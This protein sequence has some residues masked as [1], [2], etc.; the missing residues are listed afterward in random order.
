MSIANKIRKDYVQK[1]LDFT[2]YTNLNE[3]MMKDLWNTYH[4][5]SSQNFKFLYY[6][7]K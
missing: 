3:K 7:E 6:D 4:Y 5:I 1:W 2:L